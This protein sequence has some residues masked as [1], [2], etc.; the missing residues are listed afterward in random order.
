MNEK[1]KNISNGSEIADKDSPELGFMKRW[2]A[3]HG[4]DVSSSIPGPETFTEIY[5]KGVENLGR[6][7]GYDKIEN[8]LFELLKK[9]SAGDELSGT[10]GENL[11]RLPGLMGKIHEWQTEGYKSLYEALRIP[12]LKE[13]LKIIKEAGN[14]DEIAKKE[15][16]IVAILQEVIGSYP[17]VKQ[18]K[19]GSAEDHPAEIIK[20]QEFNCVGASILAGYFLKK[21]GIRNL[22]GKIFNHAT[23]IIITSDGKVHMADMRWPIINK[24]LDNADLEGGTTEDI[25][26]FSHNDKTSLN[27]KFSDRHMSK[28]R[29]FW[30]KEEPKSLLR[31]R[32]PE[33]G[34]QIAIVINYLKTLHKQEGRTDEAIEACRY[35][36]SLDPDNPEAN[37]YL[38]KLIQEKQK[39]R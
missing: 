29:S 1:I 31:I 26:D 28:I 24:E 6:N 13:E 34:G 17:Q 36:L 35:A 38:E 21:I 4:V 11:K 14:P 23:N 10:E 37:Y 25:L 39:E 9:Q 12:K 2:G 8:K 7:L 27:L 18:T 20:N 32:K 5:G 16:E 30:V 22:Y 15:L 19:Y 3:L 33:V